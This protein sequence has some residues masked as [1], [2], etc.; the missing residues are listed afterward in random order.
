MCVYIICVYIYIYI[1]IC[2]YG[3]WFGT[4]EFYDFPYIGNV[5]IP[6]DELI[7]FRGVQTTNQIYM[8]YPLLYS[9]WDDMAY[10]MGMCQNPGTQKNGTLS[11]SWRGWMVIYPPSHM[12][13][14]W[15]LS[16]PHIWVNFI[17]TSLFSRTLESW[18]LYWKSPLLWP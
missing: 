6:T 1:Y 5:I 12:V 8:E 10:I 2:I 9:I 18:F 16:N 15:V 13:N 14:A 11:Y 17:T 4:M 3:W 7:F